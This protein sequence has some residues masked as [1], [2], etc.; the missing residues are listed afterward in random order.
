[1][2]FHPS[3]TPVSPAEPTISDAPGMPFGLCFIG[4]AYSEFELVKYAYTYE[5]ATHTRLER[6]AF[7]EAVPKTQLAD[8]L[9]G[10]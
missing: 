10:K 2:G 7:E 3:N 1:M 4:T 9:C 5:Q 8:V 6:R